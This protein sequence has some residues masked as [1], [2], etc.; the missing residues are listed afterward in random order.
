MTR[1]THPGWL[2]PLVDFGPLAVFFVVFKASG[3]MAATGALVGTTLA[4]LAVNFWATR[5]LA[6]M[7]LITAV[8]VTIFGGLT[9]WFDDETFVKLKPTIVQGFF[10][11]ILFGGLAFRR[12]TLRYVLGETLQLSDEGW[13]LLTIRFALFFSFMAILNEIV[14]RSVSTDLWVDFKV[15]GILGL[16][17][18]FTLS[19]VPLMKRHM[20]EQSPDKG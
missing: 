11:L 18:A 3:L 20:V 19:Q 4:A 10:A 9:L 7:P 12:P 17:L 15:F 14:W 6:L 2:K 8:V 16:T 5:R 13:R 1:K